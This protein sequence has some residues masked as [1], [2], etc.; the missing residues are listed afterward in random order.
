[1]PTLRLPLVEG[2]ETRD[3]TQSKDT[4][5][6]NCYVEKSGRRTYLKKRFGTN[7]NFQSAA[8][9]G[10]CMFTLLGQTYFIIGDNLYSPS[11]LTTSIYNFGT[12]APTGNL[13]VTGLPYQVTISADGNTAFI[14]T[15]YYAWAFTSTLIQQITGGLTSGSPTVSWTVNPSTYP[16]AVGDTVTG[17]GIPSGTT[18]LSYIAGTSITLS[19]NA[20]TT[21]SAVTLNIGSP[22]SV[23]PMPVDGAVTG[24]IISNAGSGGTPSLTYA[25]NTVG[26]TT[27]SGFAPQAIAYG[28]GFY[29][30]VGTTT[31]G[32]AT[33]IYMTS[34]DG[35]TWTQF[36]FGTA[37]QAYGIAYGGSNFC[38][39]AY[40]TSH[41]YT[42]S[43]PLSGGWA[44]TWTQQTMPSSS[45]W[46]Q[47]AY[48]SNLFLAV[49][50]TQNYATSTN[51]V[52]WVSRIVSANPSAPFYYGFIISASPQ[53][54]TY[55]NSKF[56][57]SSSTVTTNTTIMTPASDRWWYVYCQFATSPDGVNWTPQSV[58]ATDTGSF[59]GAPLF[60]SSFSSTS[61]TSLSGSTF[62][63]G[64]YLAYADTQSSLHIPY[65][66]TSNDG[67]NWT[68]AQSTLAAGAYYNVS[69]NGSIFIAVPNSQV[70]TTAQYSLNG[71][72]WTNFTTNPL[73]TWSA[74]GTNG[75]IFT[76]LS[77]DSLDCK[78]V[79]TQLPTVNAN[80]YSLSF[81]G[82]SG[83]GAAG[84][85]TIGLN[86]TIT[87][88]VITTGGSGYTASAPTVQF[89]QGNITNPTPTQIN[90]VNSVPA[91][92]PTALVTV[93][94]Y[95][96]RTVPGVAYLDSTYYVMDISG[97][98]I[99]SNLEAPLAFSSLNTIIAN[100]VSGTPKAIS[101]YL[102]Y[103]VAFKS[104][105]TEFFYDAANPS[106]ASPLGV[107]PSALSRIGCASG[108]TVV[109]FDNALI[110]MSQSQEYGMQIQMMQGLAPKVISSPDEE[111]IL[112]DASLNGGS[113]YAYALK[114]DGHN[115]YV[116]TII[117]SM[118]AS[119]TIVYDLTSGLWA[120]WTWLTAN[121]GVSASLTY[122][123]GT[124]TATT[125]STVF[126][127]GD[128]VNITGAATGYNGQYVVY[129][130]TGST[131]FTYYIAAGDPQ[132][133]VSSS[134]GTVTDYTESYFPMACYLNN[135][136]GD[137]LLHLNNGGIYN[138]LPSLYQ[139]NGVPIDV[140]IR[141]DKFDGGNTDTKFISKIEVV[142]DKNTATASIR[143]SDNDYQTWS[144]YR[145]VDLS[146]SHS[147]VTRCGSMIRRSFELKHCD[148]SPIRFE[149]IDLDVDN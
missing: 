5:L 130:P 17:A 108:Y 136:Q 50:G 27:T 93:S 85:Y 111:R 88:A 58:T 110:W 30:A 54:V 126:P 137:F 143:Y 127:D 1:M 12:H 13:P 102:N 55:C 26:T 39:T 77:S 131:S 144:G 35:V 134:S 86:G 125:A 145:P 44:G 75:S 38:V 105:S 87:G 132:P 129:N 95:P 138:P 115:F 113:Y 118:S 135:G 36:A 18:I 32:G 60:Y 64:T 139:D 62:N 37:I 101:R 147:K 56:F 140:S 78:Y 70:V 52:N 122:S 59:E 121:S 124:V 106:P 41:C 43:P 148:N 79:T 46:T 149:A 142:S 123:G 97:T 29:V 103:V 83:T 48:G 15:E 49:N 11:S 9:A 107:V 47:I 61:F 65:I 92:N 104:Q 91:S 66:V 99:G 40:G 76:I 84:T 112:N 100:S 63:G 69:N 120:N 7:L 24:I 21:N 22:Y 6:Y 10:Q 73:G 141:T 128:I 133:S 114:I 34:P 20:Y 51:G 8:G 117:P 16:F 109:S 94:A 98:I 53:A 2:T 68:G 119:S 23:T 33:T 90:E 57:I 28:G 146:I 96:P 31:G 89:P 80:A 82:G 81:I 3:G 19:A 45:N 71:T 116:L 74:I 4:L 25:F 14:K 67:I 72:S 42:I